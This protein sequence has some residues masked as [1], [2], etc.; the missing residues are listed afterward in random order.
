[1]SDIAKRPMSVEKLNQ[2][3]KLESTQNKFLELAANLKSNVKMG[4]K[5]NEFDL[6][7]Y[8]MSMAHYTRSR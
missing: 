5:S 2:H 3:K 8:L 1:M 7:G 6:D 4:H